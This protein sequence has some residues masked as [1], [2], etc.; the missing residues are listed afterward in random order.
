M[1]MGSSPLLMARTR[2]GPAS[3][4]YRVTLADGRRVVVKLFAESCAHTAEGEARMLRAVAVS[5]RTAVPEVLA[6]GRVPGFAGTALI[7]QDVGDVTLGGLV[8]AGSITP[9]R[10]LRRLGTLLA[11]F[12]AIPAPTGARMAPGVIEQ[13]G[14]VV[15]RCPDG[16]ASRIAPALEAIAERCG[17]RGGFVWCHGDLHWDNVIPAAE[18]REYLTGRRLP[19]LLSERLVDFEG[20]TLCAPE[21][22]VAQTLV[23]CDAFTP[24]ART[25]LTAAYWRPLDARLLDAFTVFQAVRGWTFAAQVEQRDREKWAAR[26]HH[27]L[28]DFPH[29]VRPST[30]GPEG[31]RP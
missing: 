29:Q 4:V 24:T 15:S 1:L 30:P 25:R 9:E 12:H 6:A 10:A 22:D 26:L 13:A 11:A 27:A 19:G 7:S 31:A 20:S 23:T 5:G 18:G 17:D 2:T 3:S 21:Y 16:L 14:A 8:R 28:T